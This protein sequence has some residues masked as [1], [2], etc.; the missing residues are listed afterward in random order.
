[1]TSGN[2]SNDR[3]D[4]AGDDQTFHVEDR[5]RFNPETGERREGSDP[6]SLPGG[7]ILQGDPEQEREIRFEVQ[8]AD[9]VHPFVLMGL[10]GLGVLPGPEGERSQVDLPA[11]HAAIDLLELLQAKT[12]GNCTPDEARLLEQA[13]Y[14]L[15]MQYVDARE[16]AGNG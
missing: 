13:L 9:L 5:R 4:G 3:H 8:F 12:A 15:K 11:A 14:Q 10:A 6:I 2:D 1:M 7:G 16:R